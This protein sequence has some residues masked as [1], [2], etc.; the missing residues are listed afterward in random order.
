MTTKDTQNLQEKEKEL[1]KLE[2][3][4]NTLKH[5]QQKIKLLNIRWQELMS[6]LSTN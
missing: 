2:A 3:F 4:L 1:K 5:V 6:D